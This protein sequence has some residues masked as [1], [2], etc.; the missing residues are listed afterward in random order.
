[1]PELTE[2]QHLML[3]EYAEL[4]PTMSEGFEYIEANLTDDTPPQVLNVYQD[5]L[6]AFEQ[7][8]AC[9]QQM[10]EIFSDQAFVQSLTE[11]FNNIIH[12]LFGWHT[13]TTNVEKKELLNHQV[14]PAFEDWRTKINH[15]LSAHIVQ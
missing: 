10:T 7:L 6:K 15:F 2:T 11:D 8:D 1:M 3:R 5:L 4:L 12:L 14:I 13:T 9:H